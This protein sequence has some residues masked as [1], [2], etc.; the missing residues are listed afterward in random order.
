LWP[1]STIF[2]E[3]VRY[4]TA[5]AVNGILTTTC[6]EVG[7]RPAQTR[8]GGEDRAGYGEAILQRLAQ[9]FTARHGRGVSER[10]LRQMMRPAHARTRREISC[11]DKDAQK[12]GFEGRIVF[13][14]WLDI[15]LCGAYEVSL[16][17]LTVASD[18]IGT[19]TGSG[20]ISWNA[21]T[22]IRIQAVTDGGNTLTSLLFGPMG[23]FRRGGRRR[24]REWFVSHSGYHQPEGCNI[25]TSNES[26][27]LRA[28]L[29]PFFAP[30]ITQT[31]VG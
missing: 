27:W 16:P 3:Q 25:R 6:W 29:P 11:L 2:L 21:D 30:P 4:S 26:R 1:V 28:R 19:L 5:R 31:D 9:D 18:E 8:Q 15:L 13:E 20:Q 14:D 23:C 7:H 12:A 22:G 17:I 24:E 10:N